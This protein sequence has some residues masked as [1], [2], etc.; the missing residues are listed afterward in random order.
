MTRTRESVVLL[1]VPDVESLVREV[2]SRYDPSAA[3]GVP[4]HI[5]LVYPFCPAPVPDDIVAELAALV[6]AVDAFSLRFERTGRFP[7]TLYLAPEPATEII[8]LT[9]A[10]VNRWPAWQP[11]GGIYGA[12]VP[13]LTIAD[14]QPDDA[15]LQRLAATIELGLPIETQI[16]DA[17]LMESDDAGRWHRREAFPLRA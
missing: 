2:R 12:I 17:W 9:E 1:P 13:H 5:T 14:R 4:A 8:R 3:A 6:R 16:H 15:L 10:I 11:Y 7:D